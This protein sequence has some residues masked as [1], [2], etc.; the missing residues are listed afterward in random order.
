[1]I[2]ILNDHIRGVVSNEETFWSI[3]EKNM[4]DSLAISLAE[5]E[6]PLEKKLEELN[7]SLI[8]QNANLGKLS[9][10]KTISFL[11]DPLLE[12]RKR[13]EPILNRLRAKIR[14]R[15]TYSDRIKK[16]MESLQ[17]SIKVTN[18]NYMANMYKKFG[19]FKVI[20][21]GVDYELFKPLDKNEMQKKY[22][23]PNDKKVNVFV[24]S[25]H[26]VKG[27]DK[28]Q[29]M[30]QEKT[31]I[32]WILVL[33]DAPLKSGH[34]YSTFHRVS[35]QMLSEIYNCADLCVS[36]SI[37]ESFG[38]AS[39]EAMFCGIPVDTTRT[40]IFWDWQ[41][42]FKNPRKEAFDYGLDKDTWMRNWKEFVSFY[43][44]TINS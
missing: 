43:S 8:I 27:F 22:K 30:I 28:I 23:I 35:Q 20:P 3:L 4:P 18:S 12:M 33:K 14:G 2:V 32:F 10:Y 19:E 36:R 31:D 9:D 40:G 5:L 15:E 44:K 21:M 7:P 42:E 34:N 25:Q 16:Q 26:P 41:P 24:G 29:R 17:E 38:L 11:Q 37:T 1:M 6:I 39:V 13:L